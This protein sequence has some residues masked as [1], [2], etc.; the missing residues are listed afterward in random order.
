MT[1]THPHPEL[2]A[3]PLIIR[4][5]WLCFGL[6][7]LAL[8]VLQV[9]SPPRP[10][11]SPPLSIVLMLIPLW[12]LMGRLTSWVR[13]VGR[14]TSGPR[15][16][17]AMELWRAALLVLYVVATVA[18]LP[19]VMQPSVYQISLLTMYLTM[20]LCV[21]RF[22]KVMDAVQATGTTAPGSATA[23]AAVIP[24][25]TW[26]VR[27]AQLAQL[28]CVLSAI[29]M[30]GGGVL[31]SNLLFCAATVGTLELLLRFVRSRGLT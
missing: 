21:W 25:W 4:G 1:L 11:S 16:L 26:T 20:A 18:S 12:F 13:H 30:F 14:Q 23:L 27:A 10:E 15:E 29:P 17:R 28:A 2:P 19:D 22:G 7:A 9:A 5:L 6:T 3:T 31:I 24:G 8:I